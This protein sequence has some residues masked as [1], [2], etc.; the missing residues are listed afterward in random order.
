LARWVT[1]AGPAARTPPAEPSLIFVLRN[2]DLGDVLVATPLFEALRQR[3]PEAEIVAGVGSWATDLLRGNPH[4]SEVLPVDAPWFNKATGR[5][6]LLDRLRYVARSGQARELTRRRFDL[7]IDVVGSPWGSLLLLRAGIPCRLGVR[8][9]AGGHTG[10]TVSIDYRPNERVGRMALRFAEHLGATELPDPKPQIFLDDTERESAESRWRELESA[11]SHR[12]ARER[13][14]R[15]VV[16]PGAGLPEKRW[17][18]ERFA[19]LVPA[20]ATELGAVIAVVG[21]PNDRE[22]GRLLAGSSARVLDATGGQPIRE[23]LALLATS[24]GAVTNSSMALHGAAAFGKP[25]LVLLG[26]AFDSV[27]R[28]DDQWGHPGCRTLGREIGERDQI[29]SVDEARATALELFAAV[30]RR[31]ARGGEEIEPGAAR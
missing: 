14:W 7:G 17:P 20:L 28:H 16:A 6:G 19:A 3:F 23:T 2:N 11:E 1:R 30:G 26:P 24:D 18:L 9:Y 10:T 13:P 4:L 25:V 31:G 12:R 27:R 21:G 22:A 5:Q 15:L 29:A 8:G